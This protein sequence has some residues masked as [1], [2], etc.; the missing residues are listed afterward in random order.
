MPYREPNLGFKI[1][2]VIVF[3]IC[4]SVLFPKMV[5]GKQEGERRIAIIA[6]I[7]WTSLGNI[8]LEDLRAIFFKK[9]STFKDKAVIP[10]QRTANSEIRSAF[11]KLVLK[12]DENQLKNYWIQEKLAGRED[13]PKSFESLNSLMYFLKK[14]A[15]A[16]SF[17][18]ET[19]LTEEMLKEVVVIPIKVG[20][21]L[22][23]PGADKYPLRF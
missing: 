13:P 4:L 23:S 15:G 22:L 1:F 6:S 9:I 11:N 16:I 17:V 2:P 19:D 5:Q 18:E 14:K 3:C 10:V 8:S 21:D 20:N 12:A 7:G